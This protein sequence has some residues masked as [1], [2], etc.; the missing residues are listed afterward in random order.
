MS[1]SLEPRSETGSDV[2]KELG[3]RQQKDRVGAVLQM[4]SRSMDPIHS[5]D[6]LQG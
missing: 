1:E 6:N 4:I 3:F 5:S 2:G